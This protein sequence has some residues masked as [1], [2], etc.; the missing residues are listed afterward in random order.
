[1][2]SILS[3]DEAGFNNN[4]IPDKCWCLEGEEVSMPSTLNYKRTNLMLTVSNKGVVL[5]QK[6]KKPVNEH[7]F[8]KYLDNLKKLL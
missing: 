3:Y 7:I 4:E 5:S 6:T 8:R 2:E 1:M